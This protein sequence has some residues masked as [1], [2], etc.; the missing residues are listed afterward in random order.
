MEI[1]KSE[2]DSRECSILNTKL[3]DNKGNEI[4][5]DTCFLNSVV[6]ASIDKLFEVKD[7]TGQIERMI[8]LNGYWVNN[9]QRRY[10]T[11]EEAILDHKQIIKDFLKNGVKQI[12]E[13]NE[14]S[15][16]GFTET[17]EQIEIKIKGVI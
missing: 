5:I 15:G 9:S 7:T 6:G 12:L 8:S 13:F 11:K 10:K 16:V 1:I 4:M 3:K 17:K 14:V 2:K